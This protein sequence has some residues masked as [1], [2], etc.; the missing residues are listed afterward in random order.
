M[1][2]RLGPNEYERLVVQ[3]LFDNTHIL[4]G[5]DPLTPQ[6][7][8]ARISLA[9]LAGNSDVT[10]R[11]EFSTEGSFNEDRF[12]DGFGD[13]L[14][15]TFRDSAGLTD[16]Q[17]VEEDALPLKVSVANL[18]VGTGELGWQFNGEAAAIV[19]GGRA[20]TPPDYVRNPGFVSSVTTGKYQI[21]LRPSGGTNVFRDQGQLILHSN[22][23]S[24]SE[25][26]GI[27]VTESPRLPA[28]AANLITSNTTRLVRGAV[29]E[30]NLIAGSGL[31]GIQFDGDPTGVGAV[32]FARII[33][34]TIVG[35]TD[36]ATAGD[37]I[38]IGPNASPTLMNNIVAYTDTALSI[39]TS[40][41]STVVFGQLL[42]GN[43]T[44][45]PNGTLPLL[46]TPVPNPG[47]SDG[48]FRNPDAGNFLLVAGASAI[49]SSKESQEDRP[50]ISAVLS[51]L[52]VNFVSP[53]L[54]PDRDGLGQLR[55]DDPSVQSLP[56]L[57]T[58]DRGAFERADNA[59]PRAEFLTPSD[60]SPGDLDPDLFEVSTM[61]EILNLFEIRLIDVDLS[62]NNLNGVGIDDGT[63]TSDEVTLIRDGRQLESGIDYVFSYDTTNDI[64]RLIPGAG[65]WVPGV[66]EVTLNATSIQDLAGNALIS[67][68]PD[69]NTYFIIGVD[70]DAVAGSD[71][72]WHNAA[73]PADVNNDG[74]VVA[75]DA[76]ILITEINLRTIS[77]PVTGALPAAATPPPF[78]DV[79][80][81][82]FLV[83]RD[84]NIIIT[85][86]NSALPAP[87]SGGTGRSAMSATASSADEG[88]NLSVDLALRSRGSASAANGAGQLLSR[89]AAD[90]ESEV[91]NSSAIDTIFAD[92]A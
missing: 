60:N 41:A 23:I 77:N 7:R 70:R 3:E 51:S 69:G 11:F 25:E 1:D 78:Y 50:S 79:D 40:S 16:N 14:V 65:V 17:V 31:A 64:V 63:V 30:N 71:S 74:F 5:D 47:G 91:R 6:T 53:I 34:N 89:L 66:Y 45:G 88:S 21:Y 35:E 22:Q 44:N 87:S 36:L 55:I 43:N 80:D 56:G 52:G 4:V 32:R 82:G 48:L 84:V 83:A 92:W 86:I 75:Q 85:E 42:H 54:A 67:N 61:G 81:D 38:R 39:D 15:D 20:P 2:G 28:G 90:R 76:N 8:Q 58:K 26:F 46:S 19:D 9:E 68:T 18:F 13:Y 29:I 24:H 37:G 49:D 33:N 73:R 27:R 10:L 62:G 59:G 57:G 12:G 72:A